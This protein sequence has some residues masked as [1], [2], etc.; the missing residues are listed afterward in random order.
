MTTGDAARLRE[1]EPI[2]MRVLRFQVPG[3]IVAVD[4]RRGRVLSPWNGNSIV[5]EWSDGTREVLG[6]HNLKD[7]T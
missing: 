3:A 6:E 4:A 2:S 5:V 7:V 1:G